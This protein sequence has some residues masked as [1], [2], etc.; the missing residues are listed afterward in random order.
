MSTC[1][2]CNINKAIENSHIIPE[3]MYKPVY[4][5]K[6]RYMPFTSKDCKTVKIEQKGIRE[7]LLC[8]ECETKFSK[9]ETE[10]SKFIRD[11]HKA[12][13]IAT[14]NDLRMY[15]I[16]GI[17]NFKIFTLSV[18]WRLGISTHTSFIHYNLGPYEEK[19][20]LILLNDIK[21]KRSEYPIFF[22]LLLREN[23]EICDDILVS[24]GKIGRIKT[25]S[26]QSFIASGLIFDIVMTTGQIPTDWNKLL[27]PCTDCFAI[28][29]QDLGK[30]QR[31]EKLIDFSSRHNARAVEFYDL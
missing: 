30:L 13:P 20:R 31:K 1:K 9:L 17:D 3:F 12:Q 10:A 27:D 2:L 22:T 4:D 14:H 23:K 15:K 29:I 24:F 21:L 7:D 5:S 16:A 26:V 28:K 11:F 8:P 25:Y 6:H 19:L 18:L